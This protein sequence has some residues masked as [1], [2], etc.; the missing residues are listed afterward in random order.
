[1]K[2]KRIRLTRSIDLRTRRNR[3]PP[4]TNG[5]FK[6]ELAALLGISPG[7]ITKYVVMGVL[8]KTVFR[9]RAT[10]YQREHLLR[11]LA[12]RELRARGMVGL[13]RIK[14]HL[15][16]LTAE[17]LEGLALSRTPSPEILAALSADAARNASRGSDGTVGRLAVQSATPNSKL[18]FDTGLVAHNDSTH[19]IGAEQQLPRSSAESVHETEPLGAALSPSGYPLA[20]ATWHEV[21]LVP[22]VVLRWHEHAS[23]SSKDVV[24]DVIARVAQ[25]TPFTRRG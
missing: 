6:P 22:G 2:R 24:H 25:P 11:V 10:R 17:Q 3:K 12:I 9:G 8:P 19:A 13:K 7:T 20:V 23:P 18:A 16:K 14:A 15:D 4:P 21:Y 1:M 5:W